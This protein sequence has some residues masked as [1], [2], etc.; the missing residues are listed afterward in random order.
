MKINKKKDMK[1]ILKCSFK[2]H[3]KFSKKGLLSFFPKQKFIKIKS[4]RIL[5]NT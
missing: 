5:K 3:D 4:K 1:F 2:L